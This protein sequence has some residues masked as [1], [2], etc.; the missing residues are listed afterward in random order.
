MHPVWETAPS[1][2]SVVGVTTWAKLWQIPLSSSSVLLSTAQAR[3]RAEC[4]CMC[5]VT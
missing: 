2:E 3:R 4:V 5:V 1:R